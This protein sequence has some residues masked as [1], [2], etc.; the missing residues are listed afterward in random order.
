MDLDSQ[1]DLLL[2]NTQDDRL[3]VSAM[4]TIAPL[5]KAIAEQLQHHQYYVLKTLEQG[6]LMTTLSNSNQP[7]SQK[8]VVYAYP[9]LKDAAASQASSKDPQVMALPVPIIHLLFQLLAMKPV[10]SLIFYEQSGQAAEALEITRQDLE[11]LVQSQLQSV[12]PPVLPSDL[13]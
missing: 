3:T 8:T 11:L 5:L 9:T 7:D 4:G 12:S 2:R 10:D 1:I 6:W 13:A